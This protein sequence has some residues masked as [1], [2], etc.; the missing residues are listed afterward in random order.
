MAR[1][2]TS[3]WYTSAR[4]KEVINY[5]YDQFNRT[6]AWIGSNTLRLKFTEKLIE[7][8]SERYEPALF[9]RVAIGQIDHYELS[10]LGLLKC[11]D[12]VDD[13]KLL[14]RFL[15]LLREKYSAEPERAQIPTSEIRVGIQ[16]DEEKS[17]RLG[18]LFA[19]LQYGYSVSLS[20]P[21]WY[22]AKP[23][24]FGEYLD[25]MSTE[26]Y[27]SL[28]ARIRYASDLQIFNKQPRFLT[29]PFGFWSLIVIQIWS[30]WYILVRANPD[31]IT[32]TT[33]IVSWISIYSISNMLQLANVHNAFVEPRKIIDK[34]VWFILTGGVS[35]I[36]GWMARKFS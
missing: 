13:R 15:E 21:E 8:L 29:Y 20:F 2:P 27:L 30:F 9:R 7:Q 10:I 33:S 32:I 4:A 18:Q 25:G 31:L 1:L 26:S 14:H 35:I 28:L 36:V 11:Q 16:L 23:L 5:I 17:K 6:G 19:I 24:R 34:L 12:S 3:P 22:V